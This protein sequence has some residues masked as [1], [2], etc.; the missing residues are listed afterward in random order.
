MC[1]YGNKFTISIICGLEL[2]PLKRRDYLR[3]IHV[4]RIIILKWILKISLRH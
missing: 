4:K 3:D 2:C 1:S